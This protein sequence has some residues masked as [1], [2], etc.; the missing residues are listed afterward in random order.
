NSNARKASRKLSCDS[1][2]FGASSNSL[3]LFC[4]L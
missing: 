4:M 3:F 1:F 2:G